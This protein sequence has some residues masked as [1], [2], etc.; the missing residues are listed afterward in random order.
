MSCNNQK[1]DIIDVGAVGGFEEPWSESSTGYYLGFEPNEPTTIDGTRLK[2]D[3]AVW[4]DESE[5]EFTVLGPNGVGSSLYLP[6]LEWVRENYSR[7]RRQG[8]PLLARTFFERAVE[9]GKFKLRTRTLDSVLDELREDGI[10]A[11]FRFLKCDA[12]GAEGEILKGA[13]KFLRDDCLGLELELFRYPLYKGIA[14]ED[15][16]IGRLG[17]FG[18]MV[19]GKTQRKGSFD[20]QRDYLLLR[21]E[22][23]DEE[24]TAMLRTIRELYSP[25]GSE[26][27][28]KL[29]PAGERCRRWINRCAKR[30]LPPR[31]VGWLK[32]S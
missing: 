15:E 19:A 32:R 11:R 23:R 14:L 17:E 24:E 6:N 8:D 4:S 2:F 16:V 26:N 10:P 31:V 28:I 7:I 3:A 20:S 27:L 12:Q 18:F 5:K 29:P 30:V 9:K 1:I 25:Q 22:G 13:E 21:K